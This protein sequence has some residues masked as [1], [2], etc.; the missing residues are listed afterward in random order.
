MLQNMIHAVFST[1]FLL[2]IIRMTIPVLLAA[3]GDVYC[4]R[5][6]VLNIA[7]EGMMLM[8]CFFAF[9]GAYYSGNIYLGILVALVVGIL[10]GLLYGVFTV[11]LGCNQAVASLGFNM[12]ALGVTSTLN[13]FLFGISTDRVSTSTLPVIFAGQNLFF[14]LAVILVPLS[15]FIF[16]KTKWGLSVKAIGEYPRAAATVGIRVYFTRYI[17]CAISGAL[18]AIGGAVLSIGN[19]G[20][21]RENMTAG[22]GFIAFAAVIFGKYNPV[23]TLVGCLIFGA[24]DALQ[25]NL[26]AIGVEWPAN[27]FT[28]MPYIITILALLLI[29]RK[30]FVP[31]AQGQ[32]YLK[33][34]R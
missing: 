5:A 6:G 29:G 10:V 14:F 16:A 23:G 18:A 4:E 33:D 24:A 26:Q 8:G 22:R 25:L 30:S 27:F 2:S 31:K 32:H 11:T 15:W 19:L 12:L 17:T 34:A 9:L 7:I 13:K 20:L 3:L 28:M 1:A 21:F